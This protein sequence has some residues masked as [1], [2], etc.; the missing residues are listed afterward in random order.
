M[1]EQQ[2]WE[3]IQT[4][5]HPLQRKYGSRASRVMLASG[6]V[7]KMLQKLDTDIRFDVAEY[8]SELLALVKHGPLS[9]VGEKPPNI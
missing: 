2:M 7:M 6:D 9:T 3:A 1:T 4:R 8:L 5:V